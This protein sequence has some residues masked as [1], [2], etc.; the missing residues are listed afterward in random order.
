MTTIMMLMVLGGL[1]L[2]L[3][4]TMRRNAVPWA[5]Q[6]KR[7]NPGV[8]Y[9][10]EW[11]APPSIAE[12]VRRDYLAFYGYAAQTL[13]QGWPTYVRDLPYYLTGELLQTQ[14]ASLEMRLQHGRGRYLG[15]LRAEHQIQVRHFSTDGQRCVLVDHQQEARMAT[16]DYWTG[17]RLYTQDMGSASLVYQMRYDPACQ[18]WKIERFIQALPPGTHHATPQDLYLAKP[19]GRDS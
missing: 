7:L 4:L 12:Q 3:V 14:Q 8:R 13:P 11:V 1:L 15:I 6:M 2:G 17:A 9:R 19:F 5:R 10:A 16:Y 18:R